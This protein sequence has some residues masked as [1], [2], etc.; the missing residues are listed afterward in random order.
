MEFFFKPRGIAV[1]GATPGQGKGGHVIIKNLTRGYTGEIYPVNPRY[2]IIEGFRC[3]P[4]LLDVHYP[5]DFI[6]N[7]FALVA[8]F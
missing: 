5:F 8:G 6:L 7:C 4:S 3:Y 2:E 1:V